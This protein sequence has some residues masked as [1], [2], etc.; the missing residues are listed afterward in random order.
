MNKKKSYRIVGLLFF[1][2]FGGI[3]MYSVFRDLTKTKKSIQIDSQSGKQTIFI[4]KDLKETINNALVGSRGAYGIAIK[5]FKTGEAYYLNEHKAFEAGSL[6]KLW[7]MSVVYKQIQEGTLKEDQVL[8]ED[9]AT[10]NDKFNIDPELAEQKDGKVT[11]TLQDALN[12]M[13][14]ISHNYA[15]LLLTENVKLSSVASFLKKNGF[16]ESTVGIEGGNPTATPKDIALFFEKL[17][18]GELG[19]KDNTQKMIE[20][21]KKQTLNDK[22]PRYLPQESIAH[23]TGEIGVFSHDAGIIFSK[24]GDY[25][26]AILS[27][28]DFPQGAND[29]IALVSYAVHEYFVGRR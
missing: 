29:R 28:S 2:A 14:T 24:K 1:L 8:T 26:I 5:N 22:L 19:N 7:V 9:A 20:I 6:Y 3:I 13:I 10:L 18:K 15:A 25:V 23:K 4:G 12:Q 17:Y 11:F 21:L 16:Y 27:Q